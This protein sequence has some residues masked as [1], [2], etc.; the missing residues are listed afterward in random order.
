MSGQ[1]VRRLGGYRTA[2][3]GNAAVG[4]TLVE[5]LVV[6]GIIAL[7]VSILLPALNKARDSA[8][9][10][11][12]A[13]NVRQ[14][15]MMTLIYATDNRGILMPLGDSSRAGYNGH[16]RYAIFSWANQYLR[17]PDQGASADPE[18]NIRTNI[19]MNTPRVFICPSAETRTQY[20]RI[21]YSYWTGSL[22]P[23]GP[24]AITGVYQP[25][26]M[27]VTALNA[28]SK[29]AAQNGKV[30]G[31]SPALWADRCVNTNGNSNTGNRNETGHWDMKKNRPAGGNVAN[32]DGSTIWLPYGTVVT[33]RDAYVPNA[34]FIGGEIQY[35]FNAIFVQ[36]DTVGGINKAAGKGVVMG[37][38]GHT[39]VGA[40]FGGY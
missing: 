31:V 32:L 38:S 30:I 16:Y 22:A 1:N 33:L 9:R 36:P 23:R 40:I 20:D 8:N 28:A 26:V 14:L 27:K 3:R 18:V 37:G 4:F 35:P 17:V 10:V 2:S 7:L 19:Q 34:G 24:S 15:A 12:C 11:S 6:I 25:F 39:N 21:G 29:K 13:S 5:L